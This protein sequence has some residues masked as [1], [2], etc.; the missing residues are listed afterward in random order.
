[1]QTTKA[2]AEWPRGQSSPEAETLL[3]FGCLMET[4]NLPA[5]Q[6]S[7]TQKITDICSLRDLRS[8]SL[9]FLWLFK[10]NNFPDFFQYF[11]TFKNPVNLWPFKWKLAHRLRWLGIW[12]SRSHHFLILGFFVIELW[13]GRMDK[14]FGRAKRV[15]YLFQFTQFSAS[16]N[17]TYTKRN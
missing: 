9:N 2:L 15:I 8:F 11:L 1:M 5:S 7:E 13:A 10:N 6:Y 17:N 4:A 14:I 16:Q 3:A 12:G